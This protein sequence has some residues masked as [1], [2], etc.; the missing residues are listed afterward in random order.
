MVKLLSQEQLAEL[1]QAFQLFDVDGGGTMNCRV[2]YKND[3]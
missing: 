2:R 1:R 3:E